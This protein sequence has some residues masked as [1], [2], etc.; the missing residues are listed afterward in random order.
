MNTKKEQKKKYVT[1]YKELNKILNEWDFLGVV[2]K[3]NQDEYTDLIELILSGLR[4][5]KHPKDLYSTI[6]D[7][8]TKNYGIVPNGAHEYSEKIWIWA[9]GD[10]RK[11]YYTMLKKPPEQ[12]IDKEYNPSKNPG[13][14]PFPEILIII[15]GFSEFDGV[16]LNGYSKEGYPAGD[17]W[18]KTVSE[19][20]RQAKI[21][22]KKYLVNKWEEISTNVTRDE[23]SIL[24]YILSRLKS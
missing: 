5:S 11:A 20:K 1:Q 3:D 7:F 10:N 9:K 15:T 24:S 4:K 17:S 14:M 23:K 18:Q 13:Q 12:I 21:D 22:Y 2:D 19:I 16:L 8:V 6:V